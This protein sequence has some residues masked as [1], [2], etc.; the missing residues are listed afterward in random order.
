MTEDLTPVK[1]R[2]R[3]AL[4]GT[5]TETTAAEREAFARA[6][7]P[8][9][10]YANAAAV[11]ADAYLDAI[12]R[13]LQP[14]LTA[15][16]PLLDAHLTDQRVMRRRARISRRWTDPQARWLMWNRKYDRTSPM[17]R[18]VRVAIGGWNDEV[19][20]ELTGLATPDQIR[21]LAA[22]RPISFPREV[23]AEP[24]NSHTLGLYPA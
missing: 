10:R 21:A 20:E 7:V 15:L 12:W 3:M 14:A 5:P 18:A 4:L 8:L 6:L 2:V 13:Q 16:Q 11:A 24:V 1:V 19:A 9:T 23:M 17:W 22:E